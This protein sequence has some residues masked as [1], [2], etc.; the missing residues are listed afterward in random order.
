[1]YNYKDEIHAKATLK[2]ARVY[3]KTKK[4]KNNNVVS[5]LIL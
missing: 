4:T 5:D 3:K 2:I 1:M